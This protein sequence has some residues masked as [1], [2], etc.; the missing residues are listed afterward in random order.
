[1]DNANV[2]DSTAVPVAN[3]GL[4][5]VMKI[6]A[7]RQIMLLVGVA[8]AVAAGLAV[9]LWSQ[10]PTYT[11]IYTGG[12]PSEASEIASSLRAAGIDFKIDPK[13]GSVM[14]DGSRY[15]DASMRLGEQ[16]ISMS[17]SS[18]NFDE[19]SFG[20]S[21]EVEKTLL[22]QNLEVELARTISN[23]GAVREARVHLAMPP[24][25]AFL[26]NQRDAS[27]SVFL[28]TYN[29]RMLEA[30]Q[31]AS[32]T[33]MVATA[34]P[35][36][37]S[38]DVTIIDQFGRMLST[39]NDMG[40]EAL[41][42]SQL[43]YQLKLEDKLKRDIENILTPLVG[44][45][46][47]RAN[48]SADVDFSQREVASEVYDSANAA[49]ISRQVSE[50]NMGG[51]NANPGGVPGATTNQPPETGGEVPTEGENVATRNTTSDRVENFEV[52]RTVTYEKPQPA[53]IRRLSI[54]ILVD[55]TPPASA[56][57]EEAAPVGLTPERIQQFE[58]LARESV[59]FNEARGDTVVVTSATFRDIVEIEPVEPPPIWEKPIV[60]D[61]A[62]QVLGAAVVLA[63]VF[64]VV[65]PMLKNV[66]ASHSESQALSAAY[67]VAP[68][69]P[70]PA[71]A[72]PPPSF[73]EKVSAARNISG[74]DPARVAQVVKQWVGENG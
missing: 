26:R 42:A 29:G 66:V 30:S 46:K 6:P 4:S 34:V 51:A 65:R 8:G 17:G 49:V 24:Q 10:N 60:R 12:N 20:R 1:M 22:Q 21:A 47:V 73:D 63:I 56:E 67:P 50:S 33:Q 9:F 18:M 61:I 69:M 53:T 19:G 31:A 32:I 54:A 74:N 23:L 2:I 72:I 39:G 16:G 68:G 41:A 40:N 37:A 27:A 62:K 38:A 35:N 25:S 48:V 59:G 5:S 11:P 70:Q 58:Q 71:V 55:D 44:F 57:G 52:P 64:G 7:V 14:V 13:N 15:M 28:S 36:L 43:D 3:L 45:G